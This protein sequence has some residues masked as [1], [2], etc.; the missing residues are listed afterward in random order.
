MKGQH[1]NMRSAVNDACEIAFP[2]ETDLAD[3]V[4][5]N[6]NIKIENWRIENGTTLVLALTNKSKYQVTKLE[7]SLSVQPCEA[8]SFIESDRV[9]VTA[10]KPN[11]PE[12][13][14]ALNR[15]IAHSCGRILEIYGKRI[16]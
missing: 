8:E 4:R 10:S 6:S 5:Y 16:K 13:R 11:T 7:F 9:I 3:E 2:Y 12:L 14:G 15:P 1:I